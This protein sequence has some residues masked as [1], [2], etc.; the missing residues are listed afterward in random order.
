MHYWG[1]TKDI[2]TIVGQ[3]KGRVILS[4][5]DTLYLNKGQGFIY[6]NDFGSYITWMKVYSDFQLQPAGVEPGRI[7]GGEACLWGEVSN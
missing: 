3:T 1:A 6:G 2:A 7:L 5:S 4:Q